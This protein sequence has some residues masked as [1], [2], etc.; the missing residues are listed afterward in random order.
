M[1]ANP[2]R[3][4]SKFFLS[5]WIG[6]AFPAAALP[7]Q[8]ADESANVPILPLDGRAEE[9]GMR[10]RC[11]SA[12]GQKDHLSCS[13]FGTGDGDR[14]RTTSLEGWPKR[15]LRRLARRAVPAKADSLHPH[16]L[17]RAFVTLSLDA[18]PSMRDV[19]YYA[20]HADPR[21]TR[22]YDRARHNLDR[23]PTYALAGLVA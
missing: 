16:D 14:T 7:Y 20:G 21:T 4:A 19:Q 23:H 17:R 15:L 3:D 13:F 12:R 22:R 11:H 5:V 8:H 9:W 1:Y 18:G 2:I 10:C 6:H